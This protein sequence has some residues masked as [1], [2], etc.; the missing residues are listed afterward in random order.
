VPY[1]EEQALAPE[2][3]A[4]FQ[5]DMHA[6]GLLAYRAPDG[7]ADVDADFTAWYKDQFGEALA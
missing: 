2:P 1:T 3:Q 7:C 6:R 4:E 5:R